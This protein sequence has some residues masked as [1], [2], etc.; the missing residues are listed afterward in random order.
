MTVE[1]LTIY[2]GS[3]GS[4]KFE[5]Q[6]PNGD[7][8]LAR[9][10]GYSPV[11]MLVSAVAACGGYV[12][13]SVLENSKVDANISKI[14]VSYDRNPDKKAEPV[15]AIQ[16]NFSA[17]VAEADQEK[18]I[19]CLKLIAANCPVIQSLDPAIEVTETVVFI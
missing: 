2:E 17:K 14:E 1:T 5:M 10:Q 13:R 11:Q 15:S 3:N 6:T 16:I 7:W 18:A 4:D 19:R 8:I 12:Y 9:E